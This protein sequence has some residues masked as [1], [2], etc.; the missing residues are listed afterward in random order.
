MLDKVYSF[1]QKYDMLKSGDTVVCGLS[2]G[3]DS[4][5]LL[6]AL[7]SLKDRLGIQ[8]EALHV[9]HCLRGAESD[10]DEHFCRELC[11]RKAIVFNAVSCDVSGYAVKNSLSVEEAARK[12]RYSVF[13]EY[14]AHKKIATAHNANDALETAILNLARGTG[15]K[16]IA[17]IPPVRDNIVRPLLGVTRAEIE[18]FL[19]KEGQDYVTDSTNLSDDYTRNKIRHKIVPLLGEL[20]SS[21]IETSINSLNTLRDEN[22]FI[23][24]VANDAYSS[25]LKGKKLLDLGKYAP[26]IRKRLIARLLSENGLPYSHK[27][28]EEADSIALN[29][30]KLN[31]SSQIYLLGTDGSIELIKIVPDND[32]LISKPLII[33]EN[34]IYAGCIL[35]CEIIQ[36]DDLKKIETVNK[37]STFY[38]LDYDKIRGRT[39]VRSRKFG[40]RIKLRGRDFTSSIK[41]MINEK[42]P[43][44][45]RRTLHFIE[46]EEGTVFAEMI[47]IADR[48]APDENTVHFLKVCIKRS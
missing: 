33:G 24:S 6:L 40:D 25:C 14:T 20:N 10:R 45:K 21:V 9:N 22:A 31:I 7:F 3:A 42:I 26:V 18:E 36:C 29:G 39:V 41:K 37:N 2:G 13:K 43:A 46:D 15:I 47:G 11:K 19:V 27:R 44:E 48:A 12:L 28:L 35:F 30:G 34:R 23:E 38:L 5:A 17:S 1:I 4:V 32:N 16:G 8:V